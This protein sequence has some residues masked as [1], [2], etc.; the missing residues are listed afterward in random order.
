MP[1]LSIGQVA[2]QAKVGVETIR[3]YERRGLLAPPP[4]TPSGYRQYQPDTIA[5]LGFIQRAKAL[6]FSLREI[7]E[8]L[9]IRADPHASTCD[10]KQAAE[11]KL[12]DIE[13]KIG[14]LQRMQATLSV[15]ISE[16]PG[17]GP[18]NNCPIVDALEHEH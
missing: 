16:C 13:R 12:E 7:G 5:R 9:E 4:R 6:G 11:S 10:V 18:M 14:D 1:A 8:L 3:F 17:E 2:R 15:L